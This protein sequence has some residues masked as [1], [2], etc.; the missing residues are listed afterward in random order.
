MDVCVYV[1]FTPIPILIYPPISIPYSISFFK[2]NDC[3]YSVSYLLID[4]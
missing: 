2:F 3:N 1:I 4:T